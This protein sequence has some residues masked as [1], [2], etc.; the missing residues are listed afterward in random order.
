MRTLAID[1]GTRRIGIAQSDEGGKFA[2]PIEV[3]NVTHPD[4]AIEA[5]IN[6]IKKE[7]VKRI[8]IGLPINM[9]DSIGGAAKS[10]LGW[11]TRLAEK[12]A[13]EIIFVD[14]RLSNRD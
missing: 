3:L 5:I 1:L 12:T 10:T 7:E 9:D 2:T 6:L 14:E 11:A 8:V 4:Q 13:V